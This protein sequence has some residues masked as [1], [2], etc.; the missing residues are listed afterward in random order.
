MRG[1]D[2][3][4]WT[5]RLFP[6]RLRP[7]LAFHA[8]RHA[9]R[10]LTVEQLAETRRSDTVFIFGSGASLNEIAQDEWARIAE[11]DTLG[12]NWFVHQRFVRCDYHLIRGIPDDDRYAK[13][14]RPQ[15]EEYFALLRENPCFERTIF[16]VQTGFRAINGNR[17]IGYRYLSTKNRMFAWRS[18][19]RVGEP[20]RSFEEGLVHGQSTIQEC[21]NFAYLLGWKRIVLAGVDL[22][23]RR[24]FW[25]PEGETRTVDRA[26]GAIASDAH[27]QA[28]MGLVEALGSWRE[29]LAHEG[30]E[31]SVHN[32]RSLA[33]TALP[34]YEFA[35]A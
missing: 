10:F 27:V 34:V 6:V 5:L 26:R 8:R 23:D 17:A 7:W 9:Y 28:S 13:I 16:L 20:S 33:R 14:W 24:Y 21:I 19:I 4:W 15:V 11:H 32:R 35:S 3:L 29:W 25:L 12:F 31:L 1:N 18:S 22:Y 30:V 2:E